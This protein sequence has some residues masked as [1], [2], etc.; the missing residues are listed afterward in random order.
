[1]VTLRAAGRSV[2]RNNINNRAVQVA[3]SVKLNDC[4]S[5]LACQLSAT[6]TNNLKYRILA[7]RATPNINEAWDKFE[8]QRE[9]NRLAAKPQRWWV[10]VGR[11]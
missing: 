1:M 9:A 5:I 10:V 7:R 2:R 8:A 3:Y 11:N 6:R 4:H